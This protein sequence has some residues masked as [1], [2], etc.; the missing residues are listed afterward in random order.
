MSIQ[1]DMDSSGELAL[2]NPIRVETAIARYPIHTLAK[3]KNGDINI[4]IHEKNDQGETTL[5]WKVTYNSG[6][7][8]PGPLAYKTDTLVINRRIEEAPR[9]IPP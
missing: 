6:F 3:N 9:P 2:L 1:E 5:Q 4:D 8:R 7:K